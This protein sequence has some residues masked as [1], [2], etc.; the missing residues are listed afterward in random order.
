MPI[1]ILAYQCQENLC[2]H[3]RDGHKPLFG[4]PHTKPERGRCLTQGCGCSSFTELHPS[5]FFDTTI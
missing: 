5:P 2:L 4:E 1:R 3:P